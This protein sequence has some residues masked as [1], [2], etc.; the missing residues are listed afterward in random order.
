MAFQKKGTPC[1]HFQEEE[2]IILLGG[3]NLTVPPEAF[4]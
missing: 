1:F 2:G 3:K 4:I